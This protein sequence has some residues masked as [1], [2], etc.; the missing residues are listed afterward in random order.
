MDVVYLDYNCYKRSFDDHRQIKIQ[1]EALACQAIFDKAEKQELQLVWSFMHEDETILC[2]FSERKIEVFR[3]SN[4]CTIEVEPIG[5][6]YNNAKLF[7]SSIG[8]SA[9]DSIHVA[10]ALY[11]KAQFFLTCDDDILRRAKRLSLEI[12]FM[13]PVD[14]IRKEIH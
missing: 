12:T 10:S 14:Y 8:F 5:E 11:A 6:V 9:K 7:H 1:M 13:N 4:L 2:P 3:L